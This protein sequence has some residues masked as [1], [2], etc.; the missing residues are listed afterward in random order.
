MAN[1]RTDSDGYI[2]FGVCDDYVV[3][4]VVEDDARK[5]QQNLID[6]LKEKKFGGGIRPTIELHTVFIEDK[7]VDVLVVKDS[8]DTPYFLTEDY[9]NQ[10]RIVRANYIYTRVGDTNTDINKSADINH[11]EYLWRKRFLLNRPPL[12]QFK[13]KL[14]KKNEW[15]SDGNMIYNVFNP[16]YTVT[17]EYDDYRESREFYSYLMTNSSTSYGILEL[18]YFGT[19]LFEHQFAVLD[20]GR[21]MTVVPKWG[22]ITYDRHSG[23]KPYSYKYFVKESLEYIL[24]EFLMKENHE[25]LSAR[26]N[27]YE[28]VIIFN[29]E[30]EREIF[31][32]ILLGNKQLFIAEK[33]QMMDS[34]EWIDTGN[35]KETQIV[36][37]R[38]KIGKSLIILL[39][40]FRRKYHKFKV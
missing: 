17:L 7:E 34:H 9:Q 22:F 4:G 40:K 6:F 14:R 15:K 16:E 33:E 18:R 24:H 10:K 11:T 26:A 39:E 38:I 1:N 12:E 20:S 29:D 13:Q 25:A 37:E 19:K 35:E 28:A 2:I 27:L 31:M 30:L 36:I 23:D 5:T 3:K 8:T 21:Y 32:G